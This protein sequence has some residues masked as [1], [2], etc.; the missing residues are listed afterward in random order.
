M[1]VKTVQVPG[2]VWDRLEAPWRVAV[3]EAWAAYA[4]GTVPVGAVLVDPTGRVVSRGRNRIFDAGAPG[5]IAGS[6]LAHAEVNALLGLA[7]SSA[8]P[9][10]LVLYTTAEPCPLCVGAL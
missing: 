8:D 7:G 1:Y 6:R 2:G 10:V 4:A 5:Q 9:R 3:E